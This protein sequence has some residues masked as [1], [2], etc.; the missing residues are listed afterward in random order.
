M[1]FVG[2]EVAP[3]VGMRRAPSIG[4]PVGL[5]VVLQQRCGRPVAVQHPAHGAS[6]LVRIDPAL[7]DRLVEPGFQ[8]L[9]HPFADALEVPSQLALLVSVRSQPL[10][11][12]QQPAAHHS[13]RVARRRA[14]QQRTERNGQFIDQ[15]LSQIHHATGDRNG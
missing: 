8:T 14:N 13:R 15:Q 4:Q 9:H 10:R 3:A 2:V 12:P 7:G 1:P 11:D 6:D 5:H